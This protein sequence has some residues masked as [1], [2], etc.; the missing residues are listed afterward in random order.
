ME[1]VI[2]LFLDSERIYFTEVSKDD[3]K[4]ILNKIGSTNV[5]IL[6]DDL[7]RITKSDQIDFK[8]FINNY[9]PNKNRIE[10]IYPIE[11]SH[12]SLI[13]YSEEITPTDLTKL[14]ELETSRTYIGSDPDDFEYDIHM[15][16]NSKIMTV[17]TPL[18]F[19]Y[20]INNILE[21]LHIITS[22]KY[23]S[24]IM[25]VNAY[26]N[27][28]PERRALKS[29]LVSIQHS[30]A[31]IYIINN[32]KIL[33]RRNLYFKNKINLSEN[34]TKEIEDIYLNV[35]NS[36]D[37]HIFLYGSGLNK[38]ISDDLKSQVNKSISI[39]RLNPF[40]NISHS[41]TSREMEYA[42]RTMQYFT[43]CMGAIQNNSIST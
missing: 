33:F 13:P 11:Y 41:L 16:S 37:V 10:V 19:S 43:Q 3:E 38:E 18:E 42:A 35:L 22:H 24:E 8:N 23:N 9:F 31:A 20:Q 7:G 14:L 28:Y 5:P 4:I 27:A 6:F 34:L 39:N 30:N 15:I 40:R 2:S 32:N 29:M 26:L 36:N 17:I 25:S 12:I 1:N 21:D